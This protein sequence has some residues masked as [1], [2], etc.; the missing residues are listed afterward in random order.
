MNRER[1]FPSG[2]RKLLP[3]AP[4]LAFCLYAILFLFLLAGPERV[5]VGVVVCWIALVAGVRA[6]AGIKEAGL[7]SFAI[8]TATALFLVWCG[9]AAFYPGKSLR[10]VFL[11][12]LVPYL[13]GFFVVVVIELLFRAGGWIHGLVRP[14]HGLASDERKQGR[15]Q[16]R[17]S[18]LL[19]IAIVLAPL[20]GWLGNHLEARARRQR[21]LDVISRVMA[22]CGGAVASYGGY[23]DNI[24]YLAFSSLPKAEGLKHL[25]DLPM[26]NILNFTCTRL[27]DAGLVHLET[28]PNLRFLDLSGT[29]VSDAGLVH[30][31]TLTT[32]GSLDLTDTQ[33]TPE[34][35]KKLREALPRCEIVYRP[36][37][38]STER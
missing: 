7:A 32:L 10:L 22:E 8:A 25:D 17:L 30:L 28:L 19:L 20:F 29:Q 1:R 21:Q 33:V 23:D 2:L 4:A 12:A 5:E 31:E 26:L 6:V 16:F 9:Y 24:T 18:T 34:G 37:K 14:G 35:V 15:F 3:W 38:P 36:S 13:F 27:T 11:E